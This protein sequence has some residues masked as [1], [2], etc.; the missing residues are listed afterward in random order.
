MSLASRMAWF[1]TCPSTPYLQ[2]AHSL[3]PDFW[4]VDRPRLR[5]CP[6]V[7]L[8]MIRS[9]IYRADYR[10]V[11][12]AQLVSPHTSMPVKCCALM[13]YIVMAHH[14]CLKRQLHWLCYTLCSHARMTAMVCCVL[15]STVT[16]SVGQEGRC[17]STWITRR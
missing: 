3:Q 6:S 11:G 9:A 5:V 1:H 4:L 12:I 7:D 13:P 10:G 16:Y 17:H 2:L 15:A 8:G 14:R